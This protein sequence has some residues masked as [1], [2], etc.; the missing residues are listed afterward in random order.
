MSDISIG[1]LLF[2]VFLTIVVAA[3]FASTE[4]ALMSLNR[5]RL[6]HK[7]QSGHRSAKLAEKLLAQ[8]DRLIGIILLGNTLA[9]FAM[10]SLVGTIG[11]R[12]YGETG[13]AIA[14][15][16]AAIVMYVVGDLAPK[17]YGALF[18][19]R[20]AYPSTWVY[21]VLNKLL[22]PVI[23]CANLISNSMLRLIGVSSKQTASHSLSSDELRT[24]VAEANSIIPHRH[25]RMLV[26]ILDLEKT[27]V[28]DIMIPRNDIA[29]INAADEWD[30]ILEQLRTSPHT[31]LPVYDESLDN[32]IGILHLKTVAQSLA[33]GEL[34]KEKLIELAK[35]R[36]PFFVPE[37]TS[38]NTQLMN[39]Q[40]HRRRIALVVSEYGDVQGLVT[41][42]D[43]L[44][45]IVGEFTTD[46][47]ALHREIHVEPDGAYVVSGSI[48]IRTLN[49]TLGWNLPTEGPRTL[50]GL[51]L[52]YLETIP[53]PG[54]AL[55]L[56][57]YAV[58]IMQIA[59]NVVKMARIRVSGDTTIKKQ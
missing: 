7:A 31:R 25:Q 14:T 19:E 37:G 56:G 43:L 18:P 41:L 5:Y 55:R 15:L 59:D 54:T 21:V 13:A 6:R 58:E 20:L 34:N 4:T 45:E 33:H 8:P 35:A 47:A 26:S 16:A 57:A 11:Y 48:S 17:T 44:E 39:F 30:D 52:E 28:E 38:L 42:E 3:F 36:E 40:R 2:V 23:W 50:N 46:P 29:G 49:R 9:N 12:L 10:A 53:E 27:T 22:Y 51:I 1:F 32:V 24:L